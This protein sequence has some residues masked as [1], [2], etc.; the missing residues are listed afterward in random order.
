MKD[1]KPCCPAGA[2]RKV[3]QIN[4]KG[5]KMANRR[6]AR[7]KPTIAT[8][9]LSFI[10]SLTSYVKGTLLESLTGT[11]VILLGL[12]E[13]ITPPVKIILP[14]ADGLDKRG[15]FQIGWEKLLT[16]DLE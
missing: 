9:V 10:I 12:E 7:T 16:P 15:T 5:T 8:T 6:P 14:L 1:E 4:I 11:H 3:R 13:F 2:L